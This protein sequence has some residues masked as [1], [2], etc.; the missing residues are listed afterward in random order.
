MRVALDRAGAVAAEVDLVF[1]DALAVPS[2]DLTEAAA[3]R[4]VFGPKVPVTTQKPLTGRLYQGGAALDVA[5]ALLAMRHCVVPASA[6]P[7]QPAAGCELAFVPRAHP[8][9]LDTVMI[10]SRGFDG[11]NS[12]LVI[13][14]HLPGAAGEAREA[15]T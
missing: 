3:L 5:T 7:Q 8:A 2:Y 14:R 12:A 4:Q 10:S 13:R 6:G 1:P 11:F 9:Q 15:T